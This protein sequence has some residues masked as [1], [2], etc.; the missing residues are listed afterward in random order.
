MTLI[1]FL[2][3]IKLVDISH[4]SP[5]EEQDL[6]QLLADFCSLFPQSGAPLVQT[7]VNHSIPTTGPPIHQPLRRVPEAL[8]S[9]MID[10]NIMLDH[11]AI[12]PSTSLWSFP[13]VMVL[14]P[15]GSWRF[16]IGYCKLYS[17][18]HCDS[19]LLPRIDSTLDSLKGLHILPHWT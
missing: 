4:L 7:S 10:H 3:R 9:I 8:K 2:I 11:N 1:I 16:C 12:H 14:K 17:I 6:V 5:K 13:V 15:D 18:M 19:Y